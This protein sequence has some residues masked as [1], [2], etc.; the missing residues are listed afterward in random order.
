MYKTGFVFCII[1]ERN[2]SPIKEKNA[3]FEKLSRDDEQQGESNGIVNQ[4]KYLEAAERSERISMKSYERQGIDQS[5]TVHTGP[6]VTAMSAK[7][8]RLMP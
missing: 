1:G 5:P 6:A 4:K 8:S 2:Q 7:A 3:L